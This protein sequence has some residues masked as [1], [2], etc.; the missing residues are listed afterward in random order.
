MF[1]LLRACFGGNDTK[2]SPMKVCQGLKVIM[3]TKMDNLGALLCDGAPVMFQDSGENEMDENFLS[4]QTASYNDVQEAFREA[5]IEKKVFQK[6]FKIESCHLSFI[7]QCGYPRVSPTPGGFAA[8]QSYGG[9]HGCSDKTRS[10]IKMVG[11][12]FIKTH[13]E[14]QK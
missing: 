13:H 3:L 6:I 11:A 10:Q 14:I 12:A 8:L 5:W 1:S 7:F 9:L 2:P 4:S